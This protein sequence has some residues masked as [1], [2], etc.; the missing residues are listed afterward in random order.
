MHEYDLIADWYAAQR[1]GGMGIPEV[2]ALA[3]SLPSGAAVLDVGCGTGIPLTRVLL[4]RGCDVLGVDSSGRLLARLHANFPKVPTLHAPIQ[5]A[6]LAGRA[7]DAALA[8]GV[9]FHLRHDEQ[10]QAI[11]RI[12]SALR[13]GGWFLFT[14]GDRHASIDGA[15]MNGV[16]FR[17]HSFS[18]EGYRGLL[19][20]HGLALEETH[21][22]AGGNIYY[23]S[24]R[25]AS[26]GSRL[27]VPR[28]L[29]ELVAAR[30]ATGRV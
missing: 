17:Y 24:R 8:W 9:M 25:R 4:D 16:P 28:E 11:A 1:T 12:G 3:A 27:A 21:T 6:D 18:V 29:R 10:R 30:R 13:P 20:E 23:L 19:D 22:D 7:F 15:P 26:V 2:E 5:E 14:S